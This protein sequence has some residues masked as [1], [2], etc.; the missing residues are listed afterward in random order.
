MKKILLFIPSLSS[1]GAERQITILAKLLHFKKFDVRLIT[2]SDDARF[3][4]Y[5]SDIKTHGIG[6]SSV[7]KLKNRWLR[8]IH[9]N[10]IISE[11]HPDIVIS[12]LP[13]SSLPLCMLKLLKGSFNLI[14]SERSITLHMGLRQRIM[15]WLYKFAD[16]IVC[17]SKT[18]SSFIVRN[19]PRYKLKTHTITNFVNVEEFFYKKKSKSDFE[20]TNCI[21]V[22]RFTEAK[23][24]PLF[25]EAIRELC[26]RGYDLTVDFYGHSEEKD[27]AKYCSQ[28]L[29][30]LDLEN[31]VS[32]N[33]SDPNIVEKYHQANLFCLP[34][35]REGYPN[36]LCEAMSC[37]L[38]VLASN[39]SDN[40]LIMRDGY[41]GFIFDP[42][43]LQSIVNAFIRFINLS[44][45]EKVNMSKRS[46][47]LALK[48][49]SK[50]D[51]INKYQDII[52]QVLL[53]SNNTY[54]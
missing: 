30:D 44:A 11:L 36:V 23:N 34:S 47:E 33:M 24:I 39:I 16:I 22:G 32:F 17:N 27:Y 28:L 4:V 19:Y 45:S 49:F 18:Q 15:Y 51:F 48:K 20:R 35:I 9:M 50:E 6:H 52:K 40:S 21:F 12:F 2:W 13:S 42:N 10:N 31:V 5:T 46:R 1:G 38:P 3:S 53:Q 41:N 43:S 8:I 7:P 37:G 14:V 25:L 26:N 54:Q 29:K